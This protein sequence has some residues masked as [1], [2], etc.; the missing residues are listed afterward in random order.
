MKIWKSLLIVLSLVLL[1]VAGYWTYST[2]YSYKKINNLELIGQDAVFV[3]QSDRGAETW[4]QL[5][6]HPSWDILN[7][8]PAFQELSSQLSLLDSLTGKTGKITHL[9]SEKTFTL[10]YHP[11]GSESFDLLFTLEANPSDV[12][13]ITSEIEQKLEKDARL[14]PRTYSEQPIVEYFDSNNNRRWSF[15]FLGN[16]LILSE[17]S[18]LIEE[19]IRNFINTDQPSFPELLGSS[20][21]GS[22][23][24]EHIFISSKGLGNLLKGTTVDSENQL[25]KALEI[26]Q[27]VA[28]LELRL[29]QNEIRLEGPI[30]LTEPVNF[31]PS[32][33]ANLGLIENAISNRTLALTQYNLESIFESQKLINR[34]FQSKST[35]EAE[36]QRTLVDRGF[37][38]NFTGELYLMSL[39]SFGGAEQNL[40]LLCRTTNSEQTFEML[41][42]YL[43]SNHEE[44]SDFYLENEI[45]FIP[46]E[47]FPAHL[48][49]GK[50]PGFNQTF[51]TKSEDL[52]IMTNSQEGMKLILDD[53]ISGNTWGK[54]AKAPLAK[55]GLTPSA[56][57]SKL[58]LTDKI[59]STWTGKTKASWSTFLQKYAST[60]LAFP[61]LSFRINQISGQAIATLSLPFGEV[62]M[63]QSPSEGGI[64]L[65]AEKRINFG[66]RLIYGPKAI[67]NY[68]DNTEDLIVQDENN[69]LYLINSA[70]EVV[71]TAQLS[72]PVISDVFQVDYYKNG[73]LQLLV[74]TSDYIYGIDRLGNPLPEYPFSLQG[75]KITH[76]NLVDYSNTRDYRYFLSTEKGNLYLLD[77]TGVQLEGW[78]PLILGERSVSAP[79]HF[80]VLGSGDFMGTLGQKGN[81]YLF[82]R[83]GEKLAGSPIDLGGEFSS[84][85]VFGRASNSRVFQ[86]TGITKSGEFIKVNFNGEITYRN[87]LMKE[88]RDSEFYLISD[89]KELDH[90][91]FL[92]NFNQIKV[93]N[94]EEQ[95]LFTARVTEGPLEF[96]YFDFGSDKKFIVI[97]DLTQEFSYLYDLQGN[98]QT[99]LPI[100]SAGPLQITYQNNL[101]QFRIRSIS[102]NQLLEYQLSD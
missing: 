47:E 10:S 78:N 7:K 97:T 22:S 59:W 18:F 100:E 5:V 55:S 92:R 14:V 66:T 13:E 62:E 71:Y 91:I 60:F 52:L 33:Q 25:V 30:H 64:S 102:G 49:Q 21:Q 90:L 70:G 88:D 68:Q 80:R 86:L 39:E 69:I 57:F 41:R 42:G 74:A 31:T 6:S 45:L 81:L 12:Q 77:K 79:A 99:Q 53:L 98:L 35:L 20:Y 28:E 87:Q 16:I 54:S 2:Y 50:F 56:G 48:F 101:G 27:A 93:I 9:L 84:G 43:E 37:L 3:I 67:T 4:N 76:L 29:D 17:S 1:A 63:D 15:S 8:L 51:V 95:E 40:G 72:G 24:G 61:S 19:A 75:E 89:Q 23:T 34:A 44:F 46:E 73:K 94:R 32:L 82:N 85:L 11:T 26:F 83:R 96:Q 58:I 38:D 36:I 65:S